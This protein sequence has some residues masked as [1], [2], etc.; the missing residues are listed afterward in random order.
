MTDE[1]KAFDGINRYHENVAEQARLDSL[2]QARECLG[3]MCPECG[4]N[5]GMFRVYLDV[6]REHPLQPHES[7]YRCEVD[8]SDADYVWMTCPVCNPGGD[9]SQGFRIIDEEDSHEDHD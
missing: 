2:E 6:L 8:P 5:F 9:I 4:S 7:A 1:S 3:R